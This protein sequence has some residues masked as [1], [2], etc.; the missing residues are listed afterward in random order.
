MNNKNKK[1][2]FFAKIEAII[3]NITMSQQLFPKY[4]YAKQNKLPICFDA[5]SAG[6]TKR[7]YYLMLEFMPELRDPILHIIIPYINPKFESYGYTPSFKLR[8]HN[9]INNINIYK[10]NFV[11]MIFKYTKFVRCRFHKCNFDQAIIND[12][13]FKQCTFEFCS[14]N[15]ANINKTKFNHTEFI[16][17]S[18]SKAIKSNNIYKGYRFTSDPIEFDS[19]KHYMIY[20]CYPNW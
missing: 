15:Q 7:L 3:T 20:Y 2:F 5:Q 11:N 4:E 16:N 6:L 12:C 13:Y 17:G 1:Y 18:M 9:T 19:E 8:K 14:F 10:G